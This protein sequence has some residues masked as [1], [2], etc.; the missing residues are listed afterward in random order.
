MFRSH[1][2]KGWLLV[3]GK[4]DRRLFEKLSGIQVACNG[5]SLRGIQLD[6]GHHLLA[7]YG[8]SG[9]VHRIVR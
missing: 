2:A 9:F 6:F 7:A 4:D 1:P 3:V 5:K 8:E